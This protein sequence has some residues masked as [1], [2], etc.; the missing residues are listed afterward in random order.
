MIE[1][2]STTRIG[3]KMPKER[4]YEQL[5]LTSKQRESFVH[6][7]DSI[8]IENSIKPSTMKITDG[9]DVHEIFLLEIVLKEEAL[10]SV[11]IEAIAKANPHRI[12][13][14]CSYGD[15][16]I[17]AIYRQGKIWATEWTTI[18]EAKLVLHGDN[19]DSLWDSLC[20]QVIF[21][22]ADIANVDSE[23]LKKQKIK[24]LDEEIAK[25]ERM[26]GKEEQI[27]KRNILFEELRKAKRER[28]TL[29]LKD[30]E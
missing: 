10:P 17:Y 19:L 18:D 11:V 23:I 7:V 25:L 9:Q 28:E 20:S 26:H 30:G 8:I 16:E 14:L 22:T 29:L 24:T 2:P 12:L 4:F 21:G 5:K 1:L 13:F 15:T 6:L 3:R 27:A